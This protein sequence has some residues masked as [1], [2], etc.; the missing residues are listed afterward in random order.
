M[1][2]GKSPVE[3]KKGEWMQTLP[4]IEIKGDNKKEIAN[5]QNVMRHY[6]HYLLL[7]SIFS[8]S[9]VACS[10]CFFVDAC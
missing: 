10:Y 3:K 5:M 9:P 8:W 7:Y 4:S 2:T 6:V 1:F